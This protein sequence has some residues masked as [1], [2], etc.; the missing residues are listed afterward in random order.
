MNDHDAVRNRRIG[1]DIGGSKMLLLE[2][3]EAG[4]RIERISTGP[5]FSP[6]QAEEAIRHFLYNST[7]SQQASSI[8][9]A[10][11]GLVGARDD[12]QI[13]T[14][15]TGLPQLIGWSPAHA[16]SS[17]ASA[18]DV[19]NDVKAALRQEASAFDAKTTAA[20]V[21]IGTDVGAAFLVDGRPLLGADGWAGE[22]GSV[23]SAV[24]GD[25]VTL[26][27]LAGGAAILRAAGMSADELAGAIARH[28]ARALRIIHEAASALG[29]ALAT[30]IN[31]FNPSVVVLGGGTL[32]WPDYFDIARTT[33]RSLSLPPLRDRC[34][35]RQSEYGETLV[36]LG[37]IR[38]AIEAAA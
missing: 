33:A 11:P 8:G 31:L 30:I 16:L 34:V 6:T 7:I 35:I 22:L 36:A 18:V 23:R 13:V 21:M 4:R 15:C 17:C 1:V 5:A 25:Y 27:E 14:A 26:D 28:D 2:E 37:T 32:R 10:V 38:A 29:A 24:N 9:I 12:A 20:V 19:M 3:T